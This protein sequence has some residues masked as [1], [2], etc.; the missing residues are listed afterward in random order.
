[1]SVVIKQSSNADEAYKIALEL[2][3]YF[4]KRGL[5]SIRKDVKN[6][7]LYGAYV[8]EELVG[9][10]T[11]KK[12]N[13]QVIEISWIAVLPEYQSKGV[14]TKLVNESLDELRDKYKVCEVKTLSDTHPD[15][16]YKRTRDFYKRLGFIPLETIHPYP[17]WGEENPCQIFV[18]FIKE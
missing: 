8:G 13:P 9:F 3:D 18:K 11:Y 4:D 7:I 2:P 5:K 16:G 15:P 6:H 12:I 17:G 10:L 14:G 1:M